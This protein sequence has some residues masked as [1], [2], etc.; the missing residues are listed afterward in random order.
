MP[1]IKSDLT[2]KKFAGSTMRQFEVSDESEL[3]EYSGE[4]DFGPPDITELNRR[5]ADRGLPPV[6]EAT[7]RQMYAMQQGGRPQQQQAPMPRQNVS[8]KQ[9][10]AEDL[11]EKE[12][13]VKEARVAKMHGKVRLNEG[14]KRRIEMLCGIIRTTK[15]V[16]LGGQIFS[17]RTLKDKEMREALL[18]ASQYDGT[19]ESP[20]EIRKQILARSLY[21]I[22]GTDAAIFLGDSSIEAM[23]EF[24]EEI[25]ETVLTRLYSEY[26]ILAEEAAQR[27]SI[28]TSED[29]KEV[30]ED[31][32][33]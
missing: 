2:N 5:M 4:Q 33:K 27:Y 32:K 18:L 28:K 20:F 23:Y 12:R 9:T 15:S 3:E 1:S 25:D 24:L 11:Y 31:L 7:I 6:D 21:E 8:Q 19:V 16:D 29:A 14:A 10:M 17:L 13:L 26:A 30:A 22:A